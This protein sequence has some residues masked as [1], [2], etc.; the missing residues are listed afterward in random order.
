[1][2]RCFRFF[3]PFIVI[4]LFAVL[5]LFITVLTNSSPEEQIATRHQQELMAE[6]ERLRLEMRDLRTALVV[7][8]GG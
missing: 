1:L 5:Y 6:I 8:A 3:I 4:S 2:T 7:K